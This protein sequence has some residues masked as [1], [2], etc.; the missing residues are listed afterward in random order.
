V[1]KERAKIL[2]IEDSENVRKSY[3]VLLTH[4]GYN[5]LEARQREEALEM[6]TP[7]PHPRKKR[8]FQIQIINYSLV[9]PV[10]APFL[11][12]HSSL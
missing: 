4:E 6:L 7:H 3:G 11:T 1:L 12:Q 10:R 5:V 8:Y 9:V 2:I